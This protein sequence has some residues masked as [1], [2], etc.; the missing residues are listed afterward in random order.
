M[1]KNPKKISV[2]DIMKFYDRANSNWIDENDMS[3]PGGTCGIVTKYEWIDDSGY[4]GYYIDLM[5]PNGI[6]TMG[7]GEYAIEPVWMKLGRPKVW[8]KNKKMSKT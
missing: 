6:I 4:I 5:L 1:P 8:Y 2:G 7:W 3:I